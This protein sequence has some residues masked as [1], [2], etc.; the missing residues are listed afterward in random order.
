MEH[1]PVASR[2]LSERWRL[3]ATYTVLELRDGAREHFLRAW[4][5]WRADPT[6][7][8]CAKL[9]VAA[10]MTDW[11]AAHQTHA[12][13]QLELA[14]LAD[15]EPADSM[16][17][18]HARNATAPDTDSCEQA[19]NAAWPAPIAGLHRLEFDGGQVVLTLAYAT[20]P[21]ALSGFWLRADEMWID[22]SSVG[23]RRTTP[24]SAV[25]AT[26]DAH[27]ADE[28]R[29]LQ[30]HAKASRAATLNHEAAD[31]VPA[32]LA[33]G[34][35]RLA[36]E[37]SL[38]FVSSLPAIDRSLRHSGFEVFDHGDSRCADP[39]TDPS[40]APLS[41]SGLDAS[42]RVFRFSPR[43][44][45]R[46]HEPP[47]PH[48]EPDRERIVRAAHHA[49]EDRR[50]VRALQR[51]NASPPVNV[52]SVDTVATPA[53]S[54]TAATPGRIAP[55]TSRTKY[56]DVVIIGA[57][58][59]GC[60]MAERL[61]SRGLRL[62]LID[63]A[64][65]PASAASGNP[66]GVFHP[67]IATDDSLASRATRAGF[68]YT[69]SYWRSLGHRGFAFDW[70]DDG[71]VQTATSDDE[72]AAFRSAI[73]TLGLP[74]DL[75]RYVSIADAEYRLGLRP[76]F[77]GLWF[78]HGGIVEPVS[79][80]RAQLQAAHASTSLD[81]AFNTRIK[82]LEQSAHGW[83][84]LD[85]QGHVVAEARAVVL[86]NS[87]HASRLASL[88]YAPTRPIRGQLSWIEEPALAV[89]KRPV[90]GDGY[91][92]PPLRGH[93]RQL[94][95]ASYE[96]D[97]EDTAL[98]E[99]SQ[100]ENIARLQRLIPGSADVLAERQPSLPLAGRVALRCATSD[101]MPMIGQLADEQAA[102][103]DAASLSGAWPL[104][105]PRQPGLFGA[106]GYGSRGLIWAALGAEI[107]ASQ[108]AGEPLPVP[109]YLADAFDPA[110]FLMRALR[111]R[112]LR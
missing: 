70:R 18:P 110:R 30:P 50:S 20:V 11:K 62:A 31:K 98:R 49:I 86:A 57:G 74:A 10:V 56:H 44:R 58:L 65:A 73:D 35:A 92:L 106:Y 109:R 12:A 101:R 93:H 68:L 23:A 87:N 89:L 22:D 40:N 67:V 13:D 72:E 36:A 54:F 84:V 80:C 39:D 55:A 6:D 95:G 43:W 77:G 47:A 102:R 64:D 14:S 26:T 76:S 45:V 19:L 104:D 69:L 100:S 97:D 32:E 53:T 42:V 46:R 34:I 103:R 88:D 66:A 71:L 112:E 63:A 27:P 79:L 37:G 8:R 3:R 48:I 83:H 4:R 21:D 51:N 85:E 78:E 17:A 111:Q 24:Q 81:L 107:V 7:Q 105:L 108:I 9:H 28:L 52:T 96:L 38:L 60:A 25:D 16:L 61:A 1:D 75:V 90:I 59:A 91:L 41:A 94:T 2:A 33:K 99:A 29:A 15:I 82:T 5:A